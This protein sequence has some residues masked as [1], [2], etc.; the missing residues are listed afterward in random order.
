[1]FPLRSFKAK[2]FLKI[3]IADLQDDYG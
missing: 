2:T 3:P 1:M